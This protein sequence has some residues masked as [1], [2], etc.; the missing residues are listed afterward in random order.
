V[1]FEDAFVDVG[2]VV[3]AVALVSINAFTLCG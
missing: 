2:A 3:D 1:E